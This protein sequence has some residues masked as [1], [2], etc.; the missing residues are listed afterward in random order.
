M[1]FQPFRIHKHEEAVENDIFERVKEIVGN[2]YKV[3]NIENLTPSQIDEIQEYQ[4]TEL[5]EGSVM[6][7][8]FSDLINYWESN[9]DIKY[10]ALNDNDNYNDNDNGC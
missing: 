9:H 3:E 7:I 10:N 5:G 4:N 8:G 6:H 2:Y 1:T